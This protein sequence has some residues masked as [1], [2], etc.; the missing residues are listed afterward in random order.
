MDLTSNDPFMI[1]EDPP[2]KRSTPVYLL[3]QYAR[4]IYPTISFALLIKLYTI[5]QED[6]D[7]YESE[8]KPWKTALEKHPELKK[9]TQHIKNIGHIFQQMT[10]DLSGCSDREVIEGFRTLAE[11]TGTGFEISFLF[12]HLLNTTAG[13]RRL[14]IQPTLEI[15]DII[16]A[17]SEESTYT[18]LVSKELLPL[19]KKMFPQFTF[20][21]RL[22]DIKSEFDIVVY[23][24][25]AYTQKPP[26]FPRHFMEDIFSLCSDN[27]TVFLLIPEKQWFQ[28]SK[29]H[30]GSL[31]NLYHKISINK[32]IVLPSTY[33]ITK[34]KDDSKKPK[35]L[36][37][38]LSSTP[39]DQAELIILKHKNLNVYIPKKPYALFPACYLL[40]A[41]SSL[42]QIY[43][44]YIMSLK[45]KINTPHW[46]YEFAPGI[47]L[48]F[49]VDNNTIRVHYNLSKGKNTSYHEKTVH[50]TD[51]AI[52]FLECFPFIPDVSEILIPHIKKIIYKT[53]ACAIKTIWYGLSDEFGKKHKEANKELQ[54]LFSKV[55]P[56]IT[57]TPEAIQNRKFLPD[58]TNKLYALDES[59]FSALCPAT[60][61]RLDYQNAISALFPKK[62]WQDLPVKLYESLNIFL[63]YASDCGIDVQVKPVEA[64]LSSV[65]NRLSSRQYEVTA[66]LNKTTYSIEERKR[67]NNWMFQKGGE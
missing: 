65:S 37:M 44:D 16:N 49:T 52:A 6:P 17:H 51:E 47:L 59:S 55:H 53:P 64:L 61:T 4:S 42:C 41:K 33:F 13:V 54:S 56:D 1:M 21:Y 25:R 45:K 50:T 26:S 15:L 58:K 2:V 63:S 12:S 29:F 60:A 36:L 35:R 30:W 19:Y 57:V 14:V 48:F 28:K 67:L 34:K 66:Q 11:T 7:L 46:T 40:S 22:S 23:L 24:Y 38:I 32:L 39:S 43:N 9:P 18:F 20:Y 31:L 3:Y 27:S 5:Y 62:N 10:I 8:P